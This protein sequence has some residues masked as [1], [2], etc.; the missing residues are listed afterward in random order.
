MAAWKFPGRHHPFDIMIVGEELK[1]ILLV[2]GVFIAVLGWQDF[3]ATMTEKATV[4]WVVAGLEEWNTSGDMNVRN[5]LHD[6]IE[7]RMKSIRNPADLIRALPPRFFDT[8]VAN[9]V[10]EKWWE[11]HPGEVLT[12]METQENPPKYQVAHF[13]GKL[14]EDP[15][16]K[17]RYLQ[18]LSAGPWKERV[19]GF[20]AQDAILKGNPQEA[21]A[22]L[23]RMQQGENRTALLRAAVFEW[24]QRD[25][26]GAIAWIDL[27]PDSESRESLNQQ[28]ALGRAV[29]DPKGAAQWLLET[30]KPDPVIIG[31]IG[32]I[33]D[34]WVQEHAPEEAAAW[35]EHLPEG[36]LREGALKKLIS[37]WRPINPDGVAHW[38]ARLP[39]KALQTG[40]IRLLNAP[41]AEAP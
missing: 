36:N 33:L 39:D 25:F 11:S 10:L 15:V 13:L 40:A 6:Q 19:L 29:S 4:R 2:T 28:A 8:F 17:H 12:W 41:P 35:V 5:N 16:E 37:V 24:S 1:R 3:R 32:E 18:T 23:N 22:L 7:D 38:V 27:R 20:L 21:I 14:S 26:N 34:R 30:S 31:E 9:E